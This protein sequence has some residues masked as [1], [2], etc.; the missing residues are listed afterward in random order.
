MSLNLYVDEEKPWYSKG[1]RFK[2][3]GCGDCCT[4]APGYVWVTKEEIVGMAEL[5]NLPLDEFSKTYIRQV[6]AKYSLI[7]DSKTFD[8]VFLKDKKCTIYKARPVQCQTFPWWVQNLRSEEDWVKASAYCEGI[9][10]PDAPIVPCSTIT[11]E[12]SQ[13]PI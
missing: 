10:H 7:E 6:G 12:V 8:C 4:G 1:L 2:C 11:D 13:S 9:N 5:L 3:T